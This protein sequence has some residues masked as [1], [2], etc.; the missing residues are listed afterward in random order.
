MQRAYITKYNF[1]IFFIFIVYSKLHRYYKYKY[2]WYKDIP[3]LP[4]T[5]MTWVYSLPVLHHR[6]LSMCATVL[7]TMLMHYH[8]HH[9]HY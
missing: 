7:P 2:A 8:Y 9:K 6:L 1:Y 5:Q 4:V 3:G